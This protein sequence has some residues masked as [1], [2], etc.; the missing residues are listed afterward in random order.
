MAGDRTINY[1]YDGVGNR[2]SRNDSSEGLTTYIYDDNGKLLSEA[3]NGQLT[4]YTY[5]NNGNLLS[6]FKSDTDKASYTWD[7][8]NRL[9]TASVT[10]GG[11]TQ[12]IEY[13]YD[14]DGMRVASI[15]D[16]QETRYL[17]D[18]NRPHAQVLE[19][20]TPDG[21]VTASYTYGL[22]LVSQ[23]RGS[24]RFFY[25]VDGLGSTRAL[26]NA[27]GLVTDTYQYEA[28]GDLLGSTGN[29]VNHYLFAGEQYD[30][31][32]EQYYL[33]ARYYDSETG[34]FSATDPFEGMLV[35]PLSLAKYPY[36]HGN[37]VNLT[38][39]TGLFTYGDTSITMKI[40]TVLAAM[41]LVSP[42]AP[43]G[44]LRRFDGDDVV[45]PGYLK[46]IKHSGVNT[47]LG[48]PITENNYQVLRKKVEECNTTVGAG[49]CDFEGFPVIVWGDE[50]PEIR[51][52]TQEAIVQTGQSFLARI[53]PGW[54]KW[55]GPA[56][57]VGS[58]GPREWYNAV[59][60]NCQWIKGVWQPQFQNRQCDEYPYN[61]TLQG[62]P[63]NYDAGK[64]SLRLVN[65]TQ[66][67]SQGDFLL[68]FYKSAP[69]NSN[70]PK[71]SWFGVQVNDDQT[72]WIDREGQKLNIN[73]NNL[74][75]PF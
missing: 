24:D 36:V 37:P 51:Q 48:L 33:R 69:V 13:R 4:T 74:W 7:E 58:G 21:M 14:A 73:N 75:Y 50:V 9:L 63:L 70:H 34:R 47:F 12:Q 11:E 40:A 65:E 61:S 35:E 25:H 5:D 2:V 15:V 31:N 60:G 38:D 29:T 30:P 64:V 42:S 23:K 18:T 28:Y 26:T 54:T 43:I 44:N 39:P 49:N 72:H 1:T 10:D 66:N 3:L 59:E 62:G 8:E 32:L 71:E 53:L 57:P 55:R 68:N 46:N 56:S 17:L 16:G 52:H 20:Y 22:D 41:Q 27:A 67:Q 6:R 19:E 45:V